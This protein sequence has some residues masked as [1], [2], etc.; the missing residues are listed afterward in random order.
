VKPPGYLHYNANVDIICYALI[1]LL[2]HLLS[3]SVL[4]RRRKCM[5]M[6]DIGD[7]SN[8]RLHDQSGRF[9]AAL[10]QI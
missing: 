10:L 3:L 2:I 6:Y 7:F 9:G 1:D 5:E 4:S 8:F